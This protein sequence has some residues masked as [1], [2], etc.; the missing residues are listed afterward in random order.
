ML[1]KKSIKYHHIN[2]DVAFFSQPK[3]SFVMFY[4]F[5][6]KS[7][8]NGGLFFGWACTSRKKSIDILN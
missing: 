3:L 8:F 5:P 2:S 6:L 4:I 7:L 1:E